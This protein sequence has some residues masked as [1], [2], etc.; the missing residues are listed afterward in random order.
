MCY[1]LGLEENF[2]NMINGIFCK[3][4]IYIILTGFSTEVRNKIK[5]L[6]I[7]TILF[8]FFFTILFYF[9]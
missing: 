6:K 7:I 3:P 1:K 5:T 4:T 2:L 8:Y 9:L